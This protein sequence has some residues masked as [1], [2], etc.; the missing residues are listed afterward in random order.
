MQTAQ[1]QT[2]RTMLVY[3]IEHP[4]GGGPYIGPNNIPDLGIRHSD[5]ADHPPPIEDG[6]GYVSSFNGEHCGFASIAQFRDW[7]NPE[8]RQELKAC[9]FQ[10][11][12]FHTSKVRLGRKQLLFHRESACLDQIFDVTTALPRN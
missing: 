6:I 11:L 7:F 1:T 9:G 10:L 2:E 12:S 5:S 4:E 3:R 8:E